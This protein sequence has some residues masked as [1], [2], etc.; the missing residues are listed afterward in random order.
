MSISHKFKRKCHALY[1]QIHG[2]PKIS[3]LFDTVSDRQVKDLIKVYKMDILE[4]WRNIEN[5]LN[6][7]DL[8]NERATSFYI[9]ALQHFT[10]FTE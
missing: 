9:N 3:V 8:N 5:Y 10:D 2:S 7:E 4:R 1:D 6:S